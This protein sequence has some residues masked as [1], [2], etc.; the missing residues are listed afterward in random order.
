MNEN[1]TSISQFSAKVSSSGLGQMNTPRD[2]LISAEHRFII[3]QST[4]PPAASKGLFEKALAT[5]AAAP[6]DRDQ[7]MLDAGELDVGGMDRMLDSMANAG[8]AR[9]RRVGFAAS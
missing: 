4:R 5:A 7:R 2:F 6:T 8:A 1:I 9:T 3:H